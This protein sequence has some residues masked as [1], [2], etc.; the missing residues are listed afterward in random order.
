M[1]QIIINGKAEHTQE[2]EFQGKKTISIQFLSKSERKGFEVIK[3][4]LTDEITTVKEGDII[5]I[6]VSI[7]T[8]NNQI[9]YT[10]TGQIKK[11]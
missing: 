4:K 2:K 11:G 9:F 5:G 8:M 3:V 10:Q 6:P 7:S 1:A